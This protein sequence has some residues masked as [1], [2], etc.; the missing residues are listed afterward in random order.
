MS[1]N[2]KEYD[3]ETFKL[4]IENAS[5]HIIITD[6]NGIILYANKAVEKITGYS[7]EEIIGNK[8]SLWGGLMGKSY[9][10]RLWRTIKIQ[11]K[12]FVGEITNKRKNGDL[13][14][15]EV[16]ISPVLD[17]KSEVLYFVGIERDI[18]KHKEIDRAKTEFVSLASHELKNP[19]TTVNAY[20][21]IL[22]KKGN[23]LTTQKRTNYLAE[24]K[25]ATKKMIE[26]VDLLLN[27]SKIELGFFSIKLGKVNIK[28][29][30]KDIIADNKY[31]IIKKKILIKEEYLKGNIM[32]KSDRKL[33]GVVFQNLISNA[34]KYTP[35]KGA[36]TIECS[37]EKKN[38]VLIAVSDTGIGIPKNQQQKIFTRLFRARNVKSTEGVGL[39]LYITKMIVDKLKG[40]IWF[41]SSPRGTTFYILLQI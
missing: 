31:Q 17:K 22:L 25:T 34:I 26:T 41:T 9:Y 10:K 23:R 12:P 16:R 24:I 15:A 30:I 7:N 11:K 35:S 14:E 2:H 39:G 8:P 3:L 32:T 4:A 37:K 38:E 5:D 40:K 28:K 20:V 36:V 6:S 21:E 33:L 18:T 13:Y 1:L 19:L 29:I 27:V